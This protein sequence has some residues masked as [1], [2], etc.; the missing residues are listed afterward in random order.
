MS[1]ERFVLFGA[2]HLA[3]LGAAL[4]ASVVLSLWLRHASPRTARRIRI[5]LAACLLLGTA[6][7]LLVE[8]LAGTLSPRDFLPLHLCDLA[9][10]VAAW[11]LLRR[12]AIAYELL[13]FWGL[14]G[15]LLALGTP[16][17]WYGFP[18]WRCMSF[19]AL[20]GSVVASA[21]ALTL[22]CG[23]RPRPGA[24]LRVLLWTN[25]YA[26]VVA[27][28]NLLFDTNYLFLRGKPDTPTLLDA[29][30]PWPW[31]ILTC[32]AVALVLFLLLD[33]PFRIGRR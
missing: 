17:V 3:G 23:M 30:G 19:F 24:P 5:G 29:F 33:L 22:G 20:H 4:V 32:E 1:A 26:A 14:T 18:D 8:A 10:F 2:D 16:A 27:V 13:Y 28:L 7:Y 12:T 31:Y 9:V 6:A 21:A 15:T 25:A 11:A